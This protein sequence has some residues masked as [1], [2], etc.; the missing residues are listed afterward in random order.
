M[1]SV[2]QINIKTIPRYKTFINMTMKIYTQQ[3]EGKL[4]VRFP[5]SYRRSEFNIHEQEHSE[6]R[7]NGC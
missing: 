5:S 3:Q 4:K 2:F 6:T 7:K 1:Y